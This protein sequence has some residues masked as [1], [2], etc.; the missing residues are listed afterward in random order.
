MKIMRKVLNLCVVILFTFAILAVM[1]F[2]QVAK[3]EEIPKFLNYENDYLMNYF[4]YK[5][6]LLL[7]IYDSKTGG[8]Q[9]YYVNDGQKISIKGN[10]LKPLNKSQYIFMDKLDYKKLHIFDMERGQFIGDYNPVEEIDLLKSKY[11]QEYECDITTI[12]NNN[13]YKFRAYI[14]EKDIYNSGIITPSKKLVEFKPLTDS[15]W[16]TTNK[17]GDILYSLNSTYNSSSMSRI[18]Y[19]SVINSDGTLS[20]YLFDKD[21]FRPMELQVQG[22]DMLVIMISKTGT[23]KVVKVN[24]IGGKVVIDKTIPTESKC[25]ITFDSYGSLWSMIDGRVSKYENGQWISKYEVDGGMIGIAVYDD[26]HILA[27][28]NELFSHK[29]RY[30]IISLPVKQP[31][32]PTTPSTPANESGQDNGG[33]ANNGNTGFNSNNSSNGSTNGNT[34]GSNG[35]STSAPNNGANTTTPEKVVISPAKDG[36]LPIA[37]NKLD[38]NVANLVEVANTANANKLEFT[39][40]DTKAIKEGTGSLQ[41][42]VGKNSLINLPFSVI[43]KSLLTDTAKVVLSTSAESNTDLVKGLK[44]VKKL[45]S[46]DLTVVDGDKKTAVHKFANGA[47][48]ITLTLSDEELKD[49]H[50]NNLAVFYYNEDTKK[51]EL[52]ETKVDG[53]KIT[54]KTSHFSKFIIAENRANATEV[55]PKTGSSFDS[56]GIVVVGMG[57]ILLGI[58][59]L[60]FR[61]LVNINK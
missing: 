58:T 38:E 33:V 6:K 17:E 40:V 13:W 46:F 37:V 35:Q 49:L 3:A 57:L 52:M 59:V 34:S 21:D 19:L 26:Q 1:G 10:M 61:K 39:I 4:M 15:Y 47:V 20:E 41:V 8:T 42:K 50:K 30:T 28:Y 54:F 16:Q 29:G 51:F 43:D 9:C 27:M 53:N 24:L 25:K 5:D 60:R 31:Q 55:L 23:F 44:A 11:G 2:K 56:I 12:S 36:V 45:Y 18:T 22:N 48:E 7:D 14:G 32:T